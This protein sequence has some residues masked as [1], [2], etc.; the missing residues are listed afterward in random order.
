MLKLKNMEK[1]MSKTCGLKV[2]TV[3][4]IRNQH[5]KYW[6]IQSATIKEGT[7]YYKVIA[8]TKNGKEGEA[9]HCFY[10]LDNPIAN[11][12]SGDYFIESSDNDNNND[13]YIAAKK[14]RVRY[15]NEEIFQYKQEVCKLIKELSLNTDS[16]WLHELTDEQLKEVYNNVVEVDIKDKIKYILGSRICDNL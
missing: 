4:G 8:C 2:G 15:L 3:I 11:S 16:E 10:N 1:I 13:L 9:V 14:N 6:K 5:V 12:D 7:P